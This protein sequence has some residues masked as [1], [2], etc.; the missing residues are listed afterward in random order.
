MPGDDPAEI[1]TSEAVERISHG[2]LAADRFTAD[3]Q[4]IYTFRGRIA[5]RWRVGAELNEP[6][7]DTFYGGGAEGYTD[8]PTLDQAS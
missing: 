4:A 5:E 7:P 2:V 1:V 8:Y 6:N 3:R